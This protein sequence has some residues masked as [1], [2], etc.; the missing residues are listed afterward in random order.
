MP[1][2]NEQQFYTVRELLDELVYYGLGGDQWTNFVN[3]LVR[4]HVLS[5]E[6]LADA[7]TLRVGFKIEVEDWYDD[8]IEEM[9]FWIRVHEARSGG[10]WGRALSTPEGRNYVAQHWE[11]SSYWMRE[12]PRDESYGVVLFDP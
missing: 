5:V 7:R 1:S 8:T 12:A 6:P 9:T 2:D 11:G 3:N 10:A 4:Y